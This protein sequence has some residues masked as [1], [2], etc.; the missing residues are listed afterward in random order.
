MDNWDKYQI[1]YFVILDDISDMGILNRFLVV[2][3]YED[4]V[5]ENVR[6]KAI[7]ILSVVVQKADLLENVV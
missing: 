7:K 2:C 3:K 6:D 4:G 5:T 1:E